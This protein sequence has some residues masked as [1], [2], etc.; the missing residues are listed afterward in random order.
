MGMVV[1]GLRVESTRKILIQ[2][3]LQKYVPVYCTT[4]MLSKQGHVNI[5]FV[6]LTVSMFLQSTGPEKANLYLYE[7]SFREV[8]ISGSGNFKNGFFLLCSL[9]IVILNRQLNGSQE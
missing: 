4:L 9:L 1:K 6:T 8:V 3:K 2:F 5:I 7:E